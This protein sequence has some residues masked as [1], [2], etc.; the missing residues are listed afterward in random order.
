[1]KRFLKCYPKSVLPSYFTNIKTKDSTSVMQLKLQYNIGVA[2][3][4]NAAQHHI[5]YPP[6]MKEGNWIFELKKIRRELK[7][8]KIKGKKKEGGCGIFEIFIR[9]KIDGDETSNRKQNF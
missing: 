9:G 3:R 2:L 1:M 7:L 4:D 8:F 6:F 5:G